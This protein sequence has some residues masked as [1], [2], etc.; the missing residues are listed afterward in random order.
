MQE[1]NGNRQSRLAGAI[2]A[3]LQEVADAFKPM[4]G[5]NC[6]QNDMRIYMVR[7]IQF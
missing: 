1:V 7:I 6:H 5:K 3:L 4:K 2:F